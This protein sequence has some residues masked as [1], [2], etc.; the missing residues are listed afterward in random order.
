MKSPLRPSSLITYLLPVLAACIWRI[1]V[2]VGMQIPFN[3]DEAIVA[4]MAR[5]IN[6]GS[7]PIFFYGQAYLGSLDAILVALGFR[8][9]GDHILVIRIIQSILYLGTVLTT[10]MLAKRLLLSNL[11]ALFAGLLV[12]LPPVNVTLYTTVSLGGY[13]ETL[14]IGNLLLLAGL[15]IADQISGSHAD[16]PLVTVGLFLWSLGAGFGFW[17]F[18]LS[19]IYSVPV[20]LYL[21]MIAW[22]NKGRLKLPVLVLVVILGGLIGSAPWWSQA[23]IEQNT[24]ILTELAGGAIANVNQGAWILQPLSRLRNIAIFGGSVILGLRPPWSVEW[25]LLPILPFILSLWLMVFFNSLKM[26][27][28]GSSDKKLWPIAGVGLS[29]ALGF[30]FSPYGDDP[31]GRYFLPLIIPMAI[32]GSAYLSKTLTEKPLLQLGALLLILVYNIVGTFQAERN[33]TTGL[34]TQFDTI[35]QIDHRSMDELISFLGD[36]GITRGYTN[37]WVSYPLAFQSDESLIFI[38]RLP[39]HADFRYT[40]RDDRYQPYQELIDLAERTAFITTN[41]PDLDL[42]IQEYLIEQTISWHEAQIGDYHVFYDLDRLVQI[43]D[44]GLGLTTTP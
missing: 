10:V 37:Y 35:T 8:I 36:R 26:I 28:S 41:H 4:L 34:T 21:G 14:W 7:L 40:A 43:D 20:L 16:R 42:L 44:L 2:L 33:S 13:G 5:H 30:V 15:D 3:A 22:N 25:L 24:L 18:G 1:W 39:Y 32:F 23:L 6:Q 27:R 12:G 31:S 11:A 38:P 17:V 29:L 9:F 19:L